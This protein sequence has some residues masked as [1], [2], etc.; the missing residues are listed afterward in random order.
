MLHAVLVPIQHRLL[1]FLLLCLLK[2]LALA[3]P[4]VLLAQVSPLVTHAAHEFV[5]LNLEGLHYVV[6]LFLDL[7]RLHKRCFQAAKAG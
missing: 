1:S 7:V 5:L 4:V 2:D 6:E 3:V